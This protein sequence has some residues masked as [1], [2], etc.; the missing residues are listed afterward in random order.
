MNSR[1][2]RRASSRTSAL[3]AARFP[4]MEMAVGWRPGLPALD[5]DG[6]G[7]AL[8]ER[9]PLTQRLLTCPRSPSVARCVLLSNR[10]PRPVRCS[11]LDEPGG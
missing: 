5:V 9:V 4:L 3:S 7:A 2:A 8:G 6:R 10:T 1:A 11:V